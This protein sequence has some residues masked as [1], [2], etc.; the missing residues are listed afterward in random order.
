M[1][2]SIWSM[3]QSIPRRSFMFQSRFI[4]DG[5]SMRGLW[6]SS[7]SF[8]RTMSV[9]FGWGCLRFVMP[10]ILQKWRYGNL[11]VCGNRRRA[12]LLT[13]QYIIIA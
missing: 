10:G 2:K 11:T 9:N 7:G 4:C 3:G 13:K 8:K 5:K 6:R 12:A 1:S